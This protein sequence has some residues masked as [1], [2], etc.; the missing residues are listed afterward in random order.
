MPAA[1]ST[2]GLTKYYGK[3]P[4]IVDLDL[5]VRTGEVFGFLG[6]NGA[7]KST[8]IGIIA[9]LVNSSGGDARVFGISVRLERSR[10]MS[11]IGLVP[12]E[13]NFN[14]WEPVEEI[15]INQAGYQSIPRSRARKRA[16]EML[17]LLDLW[18]KRRSQARELSGGMKR[19]MMI[20]RA[21]MHE[22]RLLILD[23]PT[24]GV[25]IEI[26]R[27][28]WDFIKA[29]NES[30]T[31]VILTTHYIEEAEE[32]ADRIGVMS[33]GQIILVEEK[34]TLMR[35]LGKK[36]LTLHLQAPLGRIP[37]E[38][39]GHPLELSDD[40]ELLRESRVIFILAGVTAENQGFL[41]REQLEKIR[42]GAAVVLASRAAVVSA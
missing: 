6:P 22:P 16:D 5:T 36:Q 11:C 10:A 19:R 32:M 21:L 38:L 25:D 7:G 39:L 4:G 27:S 9:S 29:I 15:L 2:H 17:M 35:K 3:T 20:A 40:G 1:I 14:Q 8:L 28:M 31:T 33:K 37:D 41:G 18:D 42:E 13:F 30:G 12:Q 26:R 24:A 34:Q 23:E